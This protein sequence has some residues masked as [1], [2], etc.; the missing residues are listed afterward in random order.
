VETYKGLGFDS[1]GFWQQTITSFLF[2][3]FGKNFYEL[4]C[5]EH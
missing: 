2:F 5:G 3:F 4:I 1:H